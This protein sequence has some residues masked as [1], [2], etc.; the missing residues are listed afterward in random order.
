M[1]RFPAYETNIRELGRLLAR[2]SSDP[3]AREA[4]ERDPAGELA[5][6]GLPPQTIA[7]FNFKVVVETEHGPKPVVLPFRLNDQ[8]LAEADPDYLQTI[9]DSLNRPSL[10]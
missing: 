8:R 2:A 3:A 10:N 5:K 6:A 4:L 1:P 7:L 9:V